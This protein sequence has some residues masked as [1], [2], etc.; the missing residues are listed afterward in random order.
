MKQA[1]LRACPLHSFPP[2]ARAIPRPPI[3]R[4]FASQSEKATPTVLAEKAVNLKKNH[5][6]Q[7]GGIFTGYR[8]AP[9][10]TDGRASE[11]IEVIDAVFGDDLCG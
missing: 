6:R 5:V 11:V 7:D 1:A 3:A 2:F 9:N 8:F 4:Q 10:S